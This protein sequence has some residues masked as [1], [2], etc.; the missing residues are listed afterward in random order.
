M[1]S[2]PVAAQDFTIFMRECEPRLRQALIAACGGQA[3]RDAACEALAYGWEH[4]D[5]VAV[6]ANPTGYLYRVGVQRGRTSARRGVIL[7]RGGG[8]DSLPEVEPAL[9]GALESLPDRQRTV[10]VL[11]HCFEWSLSEVA[12]MLALSKST[13]QNHLERGMRSLRR[14]L[15]VR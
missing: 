1:V 13:V 6:M 15:G 10:V 12:D 5:R 11:V 4:W 8:T 3:G 9:V 7:F 14:T 2:Q